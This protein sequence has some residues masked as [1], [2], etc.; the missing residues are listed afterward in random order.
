MPQGEA[1]LKEAIRAAWDE[2]SKSYDSCHGHGIKSDEERIAW[3]G[4]L[5]RAMGRGPHRILDVGCGTGEI[6]LLLAQMGHRVTGIDLS[7][8]MIDLANSKAQSSGLQA[9]F[10]IGDAE[11]LTFDAN[12]YDIVINRHLLWTLPHPEKA[13]LEWRRILKEGGAAI[14]IDG[15]WMDGSVESRLRRL[16]SDL[17]ILVL[18]RQNPRRGW[19]SR[20]TDSALPH[21]HGMDDSTARSYLKGASFREVRI[22]SL[23]D[24]RDIQKKFMPFA[25][26][27]NYNI[28]YYMIVGKK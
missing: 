22:I 10:Q 20:E 17:S 25:N 4:A 7:Q 14:L 18:E 1:E 27:I 16:L 26:R 12:S 11:S 6:S 19:Y 2:S 24:I 21:R 13:L 15:F 23:E 28:D 8:K 5:E 9:Q 3:R